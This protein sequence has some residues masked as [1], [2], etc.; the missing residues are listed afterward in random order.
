MKQ[1]KQN[2]AEAKATDKGE[3]SERVLDL[4][5]ILQ[6][7]HQSFIKKEPTGQ[8]VHQ[9]VLRLHDLRSRCTPDTWQNLLP[10]AQSHP[11][12]E[13]LLADPFTRW[14]FQKP[15]GY[16]GDAR[17]LDLL[18]KH[19]S[20][21]HLVDESSPLGQEIYAYTSD[22]SSC[23]AVRERRLILAET[24]DATAARTE[25]AEV[26]AV[27]CGH[28]REAEL[29]Q[30]YASGKLKRWVALDQDTQ[31]LATVAENHVGTAIDAMAGS[32]AGLIRRSY[33]LGEFDLVYAAGL[34]DYLPKH[35][36]I[37]LNQRLMELVKP[38]GEFL[39]ANFSTEVIPDGYMETFMNWPL[40]LRDEQDMW[41]I[42]NGSVDRN[43]VEAEVF[44]GE[45]RHIIYAKLRK[46]A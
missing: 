10:V 40:I 28:L 36:S 12:A 29:S 18:Y 39:F 41:D 9:L 32:V 1:H 3:F 30:A 43:R 27:A 37:R 38:G 25:N 2:E 4:M 11:V 7:T 5:L 6:M 26:L 14:S 13:F 20:I 19:P 33:A 22:S 46:L 8:I 42:V 44:F 31:S 16:S 45:N 15:R 24:V 35:V 17:L 34:Y 23:V 21:K